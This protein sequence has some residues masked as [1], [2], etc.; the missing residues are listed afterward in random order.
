MTLIE[1]LDY[2]DLYIRLCTR[3]TGLIELK[4]QEVSDAALRA[5]G[6]VVGSTLRVI[7]FGL[8][9]VADQSINHFFRRCSNLVSL[10]LSQE[11]DDTPLNDD[12]VDDI[13]T[14]CPRVEVLVLEGWS[15]MTDISLTLISSL[16]HLR[17]LKL[18][19]CEEQTGDGM[20][21]LVQKCPNLEVFSFRIIGSF[22]EVLICAGANCP[23]L[24]H[25][26]CFCSPTN[27][28]VIAL[29]HGC[30]LLQVLELSYSPDDQA[31]YA[32]ADS[33]PS[34]QRLE[35]EYWAGYKNCT[36]QGLIA[37]S[38]GC[39]DLAHL[40]VTFSPSITDEAI[41]S[42]AEHCHKLKS[43]QISHKE[44]ITSEAVHALLEAQSSITSLR[45]NEAILIDDKVV[46]ALTERCSKLED[47]ELGDCARLTEGTLDSLLNRCTSLGRVYLVNCDV[48]DS[49]I[50]TLVR[51][52]KRLRRIHLLGCSNITEQSLASMLDAGKYLTL[53]SIRDC[54]LN[55][56][57]SL[58]QYY[59]KTHPSPSGPYVNLKRE[60]RHMP[61]TPPSNS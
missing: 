40:R 27:A 48:T 56:T 31:L 19:L 10:T 11:H 30:P 21:R 22:D 24:R 3:C 57:D 47:L 59:I 46:L 15:L 29:V 38:Q 34:L 23:R 7:D 58:S 13:V 53:I 26:S 60:H 54:S 18:P 61:W 6:P 55:D 1:G 5:L 39:P 33:C 32:I 43:I 2:G 4:A 28:A 44:F 41:L 37:L 17:E 49:V 14:F 12:I 50:D 20:L 36:D 9:Q 51:R 16:E 52:C 35:L 8:R 25:F 45:L 42:F